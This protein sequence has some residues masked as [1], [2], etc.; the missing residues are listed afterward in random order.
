[1]MPFMTVRYIGSGPYCY[2]NSL[3][4]VLGPAAP[5]PAVIEV[6]T[7]SPFG[8]E[9]TG[10]MRPFFH[11]P[12]WDP[13]IGL[14]TA[15]ELLGWTCV[16]TSAG[17]EAEAAALLRDARMDRPLLA[18]PLEFGLLL[19]QPGSGTA[20]G[21]DH[22]V[23]VTGT[24]ND[25]VRLHDPHGHPY[26]TL[27]AA[28]FIAAWRAV[29]AAE[30][31]SY[32]AAP[33]TAWAGFRRVHDT[34]E[35]AA[36]RRALPMAARWLAGDMERPA[37]PGS[38]GGAAALE[39]LAGIAEAGLEPW[40]H[41][42]LAYFAIRAGARRLT[43]AAACL[44]L[45]GQDKAAAIADE[46]AQVIGAL[47]HPLMTGDRAGVARLLRKLAPMYEQLRASLP[48]PRPA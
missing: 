34:G 9:L 23:V 22:Y 29:P 15:I 32:T 12:G 48:G 43:D 38:L 26:A 11:P 1:M 24:E 42:H 8:A 30:S 14:D 31:V 20:I 4:M 19:Y 27:P 33:F 40:Q 2:A 35:A 16:R 41:D 10:G 39:R 44:E 25:M 13:G 45:V 6:L 18:G 46:Q 7:G 36:L 47:Q 37:P 3:A 28:D 17:S 5:S 21:S